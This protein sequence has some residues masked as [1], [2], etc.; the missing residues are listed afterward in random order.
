MA[1]SAPH[2]WCKSAESSEKWTSASAVADKLSAP[3]ASTSAAL[4]WADRL[5]VIFKSLVAPRGAQAVDRLSAKA[6]CPKTVHS[7]ASATV[8]DWDGREDVG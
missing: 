8:L 6:A 4:P 7:R 5:D 1:R 2:S 3:I